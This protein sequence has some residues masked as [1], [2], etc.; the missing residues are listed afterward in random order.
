[1]QS[2]TGSDGATGAAHHFDS[3]PSQPDC[4]AAPPSLSFVSQLPQASPELDHVLVSCPC[5]LSLLSQPQPPPEPPPSVVSMRGWSQSGMTH[6]LLWSTPDS[7]LSSSA[8]SRQ[9]PPS[10]HDRKVMALPSLPMRP[11]R[12]ILW[13]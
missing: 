8:P 7:A 9:M 3:L 10:S 12:P 13:M 4:A 6:E 11:V 2:R 5:R 1:M